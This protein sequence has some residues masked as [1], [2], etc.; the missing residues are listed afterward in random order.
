MKLNVNVV[1]DLFQ[2]V[3]AVIYNVEYS[4]SK[5]VNAFKLK[6]RFVRRITNVDFNKH[7]WNNNWS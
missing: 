1:R 3:A 4:R 2:S 6:I 7:F 5:R